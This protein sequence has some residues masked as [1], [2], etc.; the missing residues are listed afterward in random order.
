MIYIFLK[1]IIIIIAIYIIYYSCTN[2]YTFKEY[3]LA[4]NCDK[5]YNVN[6]IN[7]LYDINPIYNS[8]SLERGDIIINKSNS[9]EYSKNKT[10][11]LMQFLLPHVLFRPSQ[12]TSFYSMA[13]CFLIILF[14][15]NS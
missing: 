4:S 1:I 11:I 9:K 12:L 10:L 8:S 13:A 3:F 2:I 15:F 14:Y 5:S 6:N 7:S